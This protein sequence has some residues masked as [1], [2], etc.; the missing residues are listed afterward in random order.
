M[1]FSA[2]LF[3]AALAGALVN[4]EG[5]SSDPTL[6][7]AAAEPEATTSAAKPASPQEPAQE[8]HGAAPSTEELNPLNFLV[9]GHGLEEAKKA[10]HK[11]VQLGKR[12]YKGGADVGQ[13]L[14][15]LRA[16]LNVVGV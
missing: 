4:A 9:A 16:K 7:A 2:L 3:L 12:L 11:G 8:P 5:A 10:V 14:K 6:G 1:R 15:N 13:N